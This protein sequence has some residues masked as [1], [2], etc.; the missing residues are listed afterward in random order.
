MTTPKSIVSPM[1]I[2]RATGSVTKKING[3]KMIAPKPTA[4]DAAITNFDSLY[5]VGTFLQVI[6]LLLLIHT[7][8]YTQTN[9]IR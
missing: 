4:Y 2:R 3:A 1:I 6:R 8:A 5:C 9:V 7:M